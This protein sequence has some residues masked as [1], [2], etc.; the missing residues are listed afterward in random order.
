MLHDSCLKLGWEAHLSAYLEVSVGV[1]DAW[2][3][4]RGSP[5]DEIFLK[6]LDLLETRAP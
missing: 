3:K 5:S 6:C 2:L 4:G 1:V